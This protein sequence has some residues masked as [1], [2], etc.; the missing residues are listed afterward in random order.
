MS[1][2]RGFATAARLAGHDVVA[3]SRHGGWKDGSKALLGYFED[4][5]TWEDNPLSGTGL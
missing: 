1:L 3:I 2:R 5:D 4:V